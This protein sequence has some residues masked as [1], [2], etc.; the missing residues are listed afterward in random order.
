MEVSAV[1]SAAYA[2][3]V[4]RP[5]E[6]VAVSEPAPAPTAPAEETN[7]STRTGT[8]PIELGIRIEIRL[9]EQ[10]EGEKAEETHRRGHHDD[11]RGVRGLRHAI[12]RAMKPFLRGANG[13]DRE[14]R[15]DLRDA[16]H[17]LGDALKGAVDDYRN[18]ATDEGGFV[19]SVRDA[20]TAFEDAFRSAVGI[21]EE[22]V[23]IGPPTEGAP[24]IDEIVA[25][26]PVA[27]SPPDVREPT[28]EPVRTEEDDRDED[29]RHSVR[30]R[31]DFGARQVF[32]VLD[33]VRGILDEILARWA[34]EQQDAPS[35]VRDVPAPGRE[36]AVVDPVQPQ[37]QFGYDLRA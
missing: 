7:T 27:I 21:A 37:M 22:P 29:D 24:V 14:G 8:I 35:D 32:G 11:R 18:G 4:P 9:A 2:L 6:R 12:H 34:E 15:A 19:E 3:P 17:D 33:E 16:G 5:T 23:P 30:H 28:F 20:L 25:E 26:E 36:P 10:R 13:L 31:L 1:S